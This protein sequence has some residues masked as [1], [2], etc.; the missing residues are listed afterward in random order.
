MRQGL[1]TVLDGYADLKVVGEAE[2]G[3][4]AITAVEQLQPDV[5]VMDLQMQKKNGIEATSAIKARHHDI[6]IIGLSVNADAKNAESMR[7]AGAAML[8]TKEAAV[9]QLHAAIQDAVYPS[10]LWKFSDEKIQA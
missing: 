8:L 9:E 2:D 7:K 3:D 5:V 4:E 6:T 10:L 1:R